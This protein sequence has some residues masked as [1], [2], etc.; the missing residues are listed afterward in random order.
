MVE[1][2]SFYSTTVANRITAQKEQSICRTFKLSFLEAN[3]AEASI[4]CCSNDA[5]G[6]IAKVRLNFR[7]S[8]AK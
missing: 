5:V 8:K 6:I 7:N 4:S 1:V 2:F 3:I